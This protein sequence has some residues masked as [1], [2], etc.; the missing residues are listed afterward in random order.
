MSAATKAVP[1]SAPDDVKVRYYAKPYGKYWR[2]YDRKVGSYPVVRP[3]LPHPLPTYATQEECAEAAAA[4][5][6][7]T[8]N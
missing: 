6:S 8:R 5:D 2:I 1:W 7:A 4:L 3:E